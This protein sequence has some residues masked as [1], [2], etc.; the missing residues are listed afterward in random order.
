MK[1]FNSAYKLAK[2]IIPLNRTL[3]GKG[4]FLTLKILKTINQNLKIKKIR[5]GTKV[6]DW[7]IPNEWVVNKAYIIDPK[8]NKI[9]DYSKNNLRLMGYSKKISRILNLNQLKKKLFVSE[10]INDAIP[11]VTS[12]YKKNWGFCVSKNEKAGLKDGKY[13]IEI[14]T[15]F[16]KSSLNF[17]EIHKKGISKKEIVFSTYICHPSLANNEI[18]GPVVAIFLSK[19]IEKINNKFSYRFIFTSETIGAIAYIK[20]NIK[21]L[22][23]NTLAGFILTCVGDERNYSFLPS[24]YGNTIAD[25]IC[26]K[27]LKGEKLKTKYYEWKNRGSDE[28][29]YCSPGVDLPFCSIMKSKYGDYKEYHTS[30]DKM[31]NVVTSKGLLQSINLYKKIILNFEKLDFPKSTKT[32]EPFLTKYELSPAISHIG[33]RQHT[34]HL[35]DYLSYSDGTNS[36][37]DIQE[38]LKISK[39][40]ITSITKILL[41]NK[42]IKLN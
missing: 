1:K 4:N 6:F 30:H 26:K 25:R 29:Q 2:K 18:S 41:K 27:I 32:C 22:K 14:D 10:K 5:C 33:T 34:L 16:K 28:R 17:G 20:K 39:N 37:D 24:K 9:F 40:K 13:K 12:Y 19:F 42:L 35:M 31:D 36:I 3:I 8:G 21:N 15:N 38:Y 11:Y 7:K 23:K